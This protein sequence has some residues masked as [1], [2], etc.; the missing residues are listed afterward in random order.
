MAFGLT[1]VAAGA[2]ETD[3]PLS[4]TSTPIGL[5]GTIPL[6]WGEVGGIEDVLAGAATPHWGRAIIAEAG[7][8]LPLDFLSTEALA[9]VDRLLLAQPRALSAEENVALDAWVRGGGRLLLF[10]D[11]LMTGES[12]FGL[13]D[14]RRPQGVALLS[15]ILAHWGL[16][17]QFDTD[18][19]E[20]LAMRDFAGTALPVALAGQ[21]AHLPGGDEDCAIVAA[22]L[23]AQCALGE[24]LALIVA[25][26][27]LLD[28]DGPYAG[29]EAGLRALLQES[30]GQGDSFGDFAHQADSAPEV[31]PANTRNCCEIRGEADRKNE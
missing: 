23:V 19:S 10:A 18:Q 17:L 14:R 2:E 27:A 21:F 29:A 28:L 15:P 3:S 13:G 25:D 12:R 11:P 31:A 26:A 5:M 30:F 16:D 22:G 24:G 20:G 8:P 6:Y 4:T 7:A 9:G 1:G